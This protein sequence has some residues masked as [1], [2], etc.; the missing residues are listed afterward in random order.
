MTVDELV[1]RYNVAL[2]WCREDANYSEALR[3]FRALTQSQLSH[4]YA[5]GN[6]H[7][8]AGVCY[9]NLKQSENALAEF[10]Q[11]T[12]ENSYKARDAAIRMRKTQSR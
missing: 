4:R 9:L 7:Y 2:K 6:S 11:V 5:I 3:E 1:A 10:R 8:W 12:D